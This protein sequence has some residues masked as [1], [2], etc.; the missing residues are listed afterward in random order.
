MY[1][2]ARV[3]NSHIVSHG[4]RTMFYETWGY[5]RGDAG[6][7]GYYDTP[8]QYRGCDSTAMLI[9]VRMGYARIADELSAAISPVGLAWL[10]VQTQRPDINLYY[11][12]V[13]DYH[14]GTTGAYLA[15]CVHYASIFRPNPRG[16]SIYGSAD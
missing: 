15:A 12:T 16:D 9:A 2:A 4:A 3:L 6:H 13:G 7:C 8:L 10:T 5:P 1:P 11:D 14:P